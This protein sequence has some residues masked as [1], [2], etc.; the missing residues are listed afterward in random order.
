M[1]FPTNPSAGDTHTENGVEYT[2]SKNEY[3]KRGR[4]SLHAAFEQALIDIET[5]KTEIAALKG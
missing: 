4:K 3:W 5:L 2:Y 1:A